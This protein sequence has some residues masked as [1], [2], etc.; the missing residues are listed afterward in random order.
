MTP[1]ESRSDTNRNQVK[2]IKS[3]ELNKNCLNGKW[4]RVK[5]ICEQ[6]FNRSTPFGLCFVKFYSSSK[7]NGTASP[8]LTTTGI[9][10]NDD[11]QDETKQEQSKIGSFFARKQAEKQ[12][13]NSSSITATT[14]IRV[15]SNVAEELLKSKPMSDDS[16]QVNS[17]VLKRMDDGK[18]RAFSLLVQFVKP[19]GKTTFTRTAKFIRRS[20]A[21]ETQKRLSIASRLVQRRTELHLDIDR[22]ELL[23]GVVFVLSGFQNPL[24]SELRRKAT[25]MGATYSDDWNSKSTHLM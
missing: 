17:V 11:E 18:S 15:L 9:Q 20:N 6:K 2:L 3:D 1:S 19:S 10:L 21:H 8:S 22:S 23:K 13:R 14:E 24:R 25:A 7:G 5:I 4:N 16:I 12:T